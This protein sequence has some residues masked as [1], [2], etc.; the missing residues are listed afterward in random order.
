MSCVSCGSPFLLT[1]LIYLVS[2]HYEFCH[3]DWR[4]G[5]TDGV[6][7]GDEIHVLQ[8][9]IR[10]VVSVSK[11][12]PDFLRRENAW[13]SKEGDEH[14]QEHDE[15]VREDGGCPQGARMPGPALSSSATRRRDEGKRERS[16]SG[17]RSTRR[18]AGN[19]KRD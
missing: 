16:D 8:T 4:P 6:S 5:F 17:E 10:S 9:E 7:K 18:L 15:H 1:R 19:L 13:D 2:E 12:I 3:A 11:G 14:G